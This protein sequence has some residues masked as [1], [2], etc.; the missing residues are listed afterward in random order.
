MSIRPVK[1]VTQAQLREECE[2]L[3]RGTF[4]KQDR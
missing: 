4:L 2:Q 3:E 1:K